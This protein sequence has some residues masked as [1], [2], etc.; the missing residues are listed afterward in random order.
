[1]LYLSRRRKAM[2][3]LVD[4]RG[5]DRVGAPYNFWFLIGRRY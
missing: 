4:A 1:M 5:E 3:R 2:A